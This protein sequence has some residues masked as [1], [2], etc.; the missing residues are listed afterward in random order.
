MRAQND[1]PSIIDGA[2]T[3]KVV[4]QFDSVSQAQL[5]LRAHTFISDWVGPNNNS[6][7]SIEF[8]D[9]ESATIISKGSVFMGYFKSNMFYGYNVYADY[10]LTIKCKDG[11]C[12]YVVK[13][14]SMSFHWTANNIQD[15]TIPIDRILPTYNYKS[16]VVEKRVPPTYSPQL[17]QLIKD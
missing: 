15:E 9:K 1:E 3:Y 7:R 14:P 11:R 6:K 17:P 2:L 13:I 5:Y 16:N 8:D 10:T 12:Q 4:N